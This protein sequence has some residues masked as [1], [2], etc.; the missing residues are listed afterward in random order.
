MAIPEPGAFHAEP[1]ADRVEPECALD[2]LVCRIFLS[3]NRSLERMRRV[4]GAFI[5]DI[6][7]DPAPLRPES[8]KVTL[9]RVD[10]TTYRTLRARSV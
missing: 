10:R 6:E 8:T 9:E 1:L 5:C 3:P 4:R 2:S 7:D